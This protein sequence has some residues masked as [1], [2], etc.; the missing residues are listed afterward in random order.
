M[1][2][3]IKERQ[4]SWKEDKT[5]PERMQEKVRSYAKGCRSFCKHTRVELN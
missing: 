1:R 4:T 2:W 5:D 3:L